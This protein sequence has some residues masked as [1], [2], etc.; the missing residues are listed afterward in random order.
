M[1]ILYSTSIFKGYSSVNF[2]KSQILSISTSIFT[3]LIFI[4]GGGRGGGK[5][6]LDKPGG[7]LVLF[8]NTIDSRFDGNK[9]DKSKSSLLLN[10]N[11]V[12]LELGLFF[13]IS[14][15]NSSNDFFFG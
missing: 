10:L 5:R 4:C 15:K 9:L 14:F 12:V 1:L 6:L 7:G 2:I 3:F 11:I 13:D 8:P